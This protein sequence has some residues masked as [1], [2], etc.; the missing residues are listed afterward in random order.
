MLCIVTQIL[1]YSTQF[2]LILLNYNFTQWSIPVTKVTKLQVKTMANISLAINNLLVQTTPRNGEQRSRRVH[3]VY[4]NPTIDTGAYRH[5]FCVSD[6]VSVAPGYYTLVP[7]TY[8]PGEE[9]NF[10]LHVSSSKELDI[11]EIQY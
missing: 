1:L 9:G 8:M 6:V 11:R 7:S 10:V 3:Q 2:G 5:G 4:S